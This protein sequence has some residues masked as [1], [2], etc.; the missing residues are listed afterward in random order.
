MAEAAAQVVVAA[1]VDVAVA[2]NKSLETKR[3]E[4]TICDENYRMS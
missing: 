4:E 2:D 3:K 1:V